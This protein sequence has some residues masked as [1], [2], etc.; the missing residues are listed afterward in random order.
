MAVS[1]SPVLTYGSYF[2]FMKRSKRCSNAK[3]GVSE[4][5]VRKI[6]SLKLEK[7]VHS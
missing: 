1:L 6:L 2:G 3:G 5:R 7:I 4:S